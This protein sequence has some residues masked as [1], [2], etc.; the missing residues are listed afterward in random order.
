[1]ASYVVDLEQIVPAQR[2]L[3][4]PKA[5]ALAQL[6]QADG[7]DVPSG[8]CVTTDAFPVTPAGAGSTTAVAVPD[9]VAAEI[10]EALA[11]LGE[12]TPALS[13]AGGARSDRVR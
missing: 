1:M 8:F 7:I 3:V 5:A 6:A 12:R 9:D 10:A 11:R 2:A 13:S 4:G